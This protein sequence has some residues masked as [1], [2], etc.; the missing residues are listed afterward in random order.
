MHTYT[1]ELLHAKVPSFAV[2]KAG[3]RLEYVHV[4]MYIY[5]YIC[6]YT[7][8]Y[9]YIHICIHIYIYICIYIC[10]YVYIYIYI[11]ILAWNN[12]IGPRF[13]FVGF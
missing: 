1:C 13:Y 9:V 3:I 11:Y 8:M 4:C 2:K 7:C 6:M 12:E 5:I 10:M